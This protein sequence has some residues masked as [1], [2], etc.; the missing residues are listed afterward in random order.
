M[1]PRNSRMIEHAATRLL[2]YGSAKVLHAKVRVPR[3]RG[4]SNGETNT[5]W[6]PNQVN[7][8]TCLAG[9]PRKCLFGG[10]SVWV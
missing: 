3:R 6:N 8:G 5:V 4:R 7:V 9:L 2:K 10:G 1:H